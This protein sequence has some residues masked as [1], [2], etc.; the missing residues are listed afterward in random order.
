MRVEKRRDHFDVVRD[1]RLPASDLVRSQLRWFAT[2]A[3]PSFKVFYDARLFAE[4]H[5]PFG[6]VAPRPLLF[7]A[8]LG[9][10]S[11]TMV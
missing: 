5:V 1:L 10:R 6:V 9:A 4:G 11:G 3:G 8:M 7:A 2:K